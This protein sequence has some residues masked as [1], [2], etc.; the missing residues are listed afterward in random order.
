MRLQLQSLTDGCVI[1][2][3]ASAGQTFAQAI[4]LSSALKPKALCGGLGLCGRCRIRYNTQAPQAS[5]AEH[6]YFSSQELKA[7]WRLA[8]RHKVPAGNGL[9]EISLPSL[10]LANS[11]RSQPVRYKKEKAFLGIDLGTTS[12]HWRCVTSDGKKLA[13]GNLLNPQLAAGPDVISRLEYCSSP[14]RKE[15]LAN[16]VL[17]SIAEIINQLEFQNFTI[18]RLCVAANSVMTHIL[19]KCDLRGL[20]SAP[21]Y[22]ACPNAQSISLQIQ[23][24]KLPCIIPPLAAP[25]VG[26]DISAGLL[27]CTEQDLKRPLLLA[28]LGTNA[29]LALLLPDKKLYLASA[30]LGPAMEGIGPKCGQPAGP[31]VAVA[32]SLSSSGLIASFYNKESGPYLSATGYLS[33]ISHLLN[34]GLMDRDG[35]FTHSPLAM[36]LGRRLQAALCRING[37]EALDLGSGLYLTSGDIELLL[38]VKAS[39]RVALKRLFESAEISE[40]AIE[41]FVLVGAISE[42]SSTADLINLGFIPGPLAPKLHRIVNTSLD[43]ACLLAAKPQLL[44]GL[45]SLCSEAITIDLANDPS[46]LK[47]YLAEMTWQ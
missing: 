2:V 39:F 42:N 19:L 30:P 25:F 44:S 32:F 46:F 18:E 12:I 10:E 16:L 28:D 24:K 23:D 13:G 21:Y 27:A 35:H 6:S 26:A 41:T 33:V 22:L 29:E 17:V 11:C 15:Q 1:E 47:D 8:C 7:G 37:E 20:S 38:K 14:E 4:W 45:A 43:G 40:K 36:P 9:I 34:L 3:E 31:G 5:A